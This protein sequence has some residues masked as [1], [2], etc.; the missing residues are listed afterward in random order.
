MILLSCYTNYRK[1]HPFHLAT[2]PFD[3]RIL[4]FSKSQVIQCW[5]QI[6]ILIANQN[7]NQI[8]LR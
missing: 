4:F 3:L 7:K 6:M 8:N 5:G 2:H 1:V